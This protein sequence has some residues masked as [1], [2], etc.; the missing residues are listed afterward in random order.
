MEVEDEDECWRKLDEKRRKMQNELR[1]VERLSFASKEMQ[2]NLM[3]SMQRQLRISCLC[4]KRCKRGHKRHKVSKRGENY[5]KKACTLL[6]DTVDKNTM[7]DAEMEAEL[8][9]LQAGEKRSRH[10]SQ[11]VECLWRWWWNTFSPWEM[12]IR[13]SLIRCSVPKDPHKI[14]D[15]YSSCA[16]ARDARKRRRTK[17]QW[18]WTREIKS[19]PIELHQRAVWSLIFL[20]YG[21]YLVKAEVQKDHAREVH[22][23]MM[24]WEI[25]CRKPKRKKNSQGKDPRTLVENSWEPQ[26][27]P[28]H[29][30]RK[31]TREPSKHQLKGGGFRKSE[32]KRSGK[33][34]KKKKKETMM[35]KR[36]L[37]WANGKERRRIEEKAEREEQESQ[38]ETISG[39]IWKMALP[40]LVS[41]LTDFGQTDFGQFFDRLWPIVVL[42]DFGQTDFGQF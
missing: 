1:E 32:K 17:G 40:S 33:E 20:V 9:G 36:S 25:W 34:R 5:R 15:S 2:E 42:T 19:Q 38:D 7:A 27:K 13:R 28:N 39:K 10:A 3:E 14:R 6:S 16:H 30:A 22:P 29:T 18:K 41:V 24:I 4:T 12:R 26:Y 8:Q 23:G 11:A 21:V 35:H 31:R 37:W